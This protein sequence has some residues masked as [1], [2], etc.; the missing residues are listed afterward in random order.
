[1]TLIW[2]LL[3]GHLSLT[4]TFGFALAGVVG[5]TVVLT[6]M[7]AY[8]DVLPLF[9]S[10]DS[11][12]KGDFLVLSK[13]VG[14]LQTLGIGSTD[15]SDSEISDLRSQPFVREVGAFTPADYRVTGSAGVGGVG[16]TTYLFFE[17]VP[18]HFLDVDRTAWNY[19][20][21]GAEVPIVIPRNYLNL[22][23]FGFAK[24]QGL[25]QISERIFSKVTLG[26]E[27][28]GNGRTE[29]LRGRIVGLS[30]RLNTI[31][32]PEAFIRWSNDRFGR[33][34]ENLR[35]SRVIV[36][37]NR[38]ADAEV[39]DYLRSRGYEVEGGMRDEGREARLLRI[40][41]SGTAAVGAVFSLMS[42]YVLLLSIFLLLQRDIR[43]IETLLLL[44]YT[45]RQVARPYRMLALGLNLAVFVAGLGVWAAL[46][47]GY[48]PLLES[49]QE[50]Y[51]PGG[52]MLSVGCGLLL[53]LGLALLSGVAVGR[54]IGRLT[55]RRM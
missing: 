30:N 42:F 36:E 32:V 22:Y 8:R 54:R 48:L 25:P 55:R 16:F 24:S 3:R 51:V 18:D 38:P 28:S 2:K 4:Q 21:G 13:R 45:P 23:N 43:K 1:M 19:E 41:T 5:M 7:Q 31:L 9:E 49:M 39:E 33:G 44:G 40:V 29:H 34:G 53:S 35:P 50:G 14:T 11:F 12:A 20:P 10:P 17:S 37:T 26:I 27:L 52:W 47:S 46:R 15:F 6:S